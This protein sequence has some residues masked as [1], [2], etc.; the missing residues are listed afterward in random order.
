MSPTAATIGRDSLHRQSKAGSHI[1]WAKLDSK[2][3]L[4]LGGIQPVP[5]N[6]KP[7]T[8]YSQW[9]KAQALQELSPRFHALDTLCEALK[10]LLHDT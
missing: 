4:K 7:L 3:M 10:T 8:M 5:L 2:L 1:G 9:S 6:P